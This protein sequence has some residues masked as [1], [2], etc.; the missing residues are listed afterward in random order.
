MAT[1]IWRLLRPIAAAN[2]YRKARILR[3]PRILKRKLAPEENRPAIRLDP[4][5][6][7]ASLA[8]A[9]ISADQ[10]VVGFAGHD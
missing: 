8:Q 5:R 9:G 2:Q 6:V 4:A 7:V 10:L 3:K 1:K